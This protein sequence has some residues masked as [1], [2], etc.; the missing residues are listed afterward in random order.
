V[1]SGTL[2]GTRTQAILNDEPYDE[3]KQL[4]IRNQR[5]GSR[6]ETLSRLERAEELMPAGDGAA[7][8]NA[9]PSPDRDPDTI[10]AF[11]GERG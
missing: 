8:E 7:P 11:S 9:P 3:E 5:E 2:E 1:S 4:R 6:Q 10:D